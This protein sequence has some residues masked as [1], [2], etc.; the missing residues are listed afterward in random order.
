MKTKPNEHGCQPALDVLLSRME[1]DDFTPGEVQ[2]LCVQFPD[3]AEELESTFAL[4]HSM[5]ELEVPEPS[6]AMHAG[7]YRSL[8]ELTAEAE[9]KNQRPLRIDWWSWNG[10]SLKWAVLAGVFLLGL[11]SGN[12]FQPLTSDGELAGND[13]DQRKKISASYV[14]LT[15]SES[16]TDRLQA[17]QLAR[18][19]EDP[20]DRIIEALNHTLIHD[21]NVNVRLSAIE[22]MI[23]F[24]DNPKVR[25]NL[26]RAIPFQTDPLVQ[27]ALAEVMMAM[28]DKRAIEQLKQLLQRDEVEVEVKMQ[29]QETIETLL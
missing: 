13:N 18:Q 21:S 19:L 11:I 25:E 15:S 16:A 29:L 23:H 1:Q 24:A 22:T 27:L 10:L 4:W 12:F 8:H 5:D 28:K 2:E 17:M 14:M 7:F 20:D 3:C 9:R 26:I 6:A